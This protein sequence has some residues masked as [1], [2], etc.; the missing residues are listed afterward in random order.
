MYETFLHK[1]YTKKKL[2]HKNI[3]LWLY[4]AISAYGC[5]SA[6]SLIIFESKIYKMVISTIKKRSK[7]TVYN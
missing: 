2:F 5:F 6:N 7:V 3:N 4:L 1:K